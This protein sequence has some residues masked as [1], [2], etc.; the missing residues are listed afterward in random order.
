[1]LNKY[2]LGVTVAATAL[3]FSAGASSAE[4]YRI[5]VMDQAFFPEVSYIAAGDVLIFVNM[6]GQTRD[7]T[8][9]DES[10]V[11]PALADGLEASLIVT[12]GMADEF[13]TGGAEGSVLGKLSF[14]SASDTPPEN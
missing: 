11:V 10:W 5:M 6:S 3:T 4:Q 2:I 13:S 12:A 9:S 14:G 7:I 1:M 8:A